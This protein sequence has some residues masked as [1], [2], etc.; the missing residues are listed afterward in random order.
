[1]IDPEHLIKNRRIMKRLWETIPPKAYGLFTRD[2]IKS[3]IYYIICE[4]SP[5]WNSK[6]S[7]LIYFLTLMLSKFMSNK[8]TS[9]ELIRENEI[10]SS[11][12]HIYDDSYTYEQ[13]EAINFLK[14]LPLT[15]IN[16]MTEYLVNEDTPDINFDT[17]GIFAYADLI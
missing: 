6:K 3:D 4:F 9:E 17:R 14:G 12:F 7:S 5:K 11:M 16:N 15:L 13:R 1:M 2:E 8:I 10:S